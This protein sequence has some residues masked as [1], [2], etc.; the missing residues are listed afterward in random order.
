M[1]FTVHSSSLN[2][3]TN[4]SQLGQKVWNYWEFKN[5]LSAAVLFKISSWWTYHVAVWISVSYCLDSF[6][7]NFPERLAEEVSY[8]TV[9]YPYYSL[10]SYLRLYPLLRLSIWTK[11]NSSSISS[12]IFSLHCGAALGI[13]IH[14][15]GEWA[16]NFCQQHY[17][18]YATSWLKNT[19]V[20]VCVFLDWFMLWSKT[21]KHEEEKKTLAPLKESNLFSPHSY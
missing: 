20:C 4:R 16:S 6:V 2:T 11:R 10:C 18:Y 19:G 14:R 3:W 21:F 9:Q 13:S 7:P 1:Y 15:A 12:Q 8:C 5:K 17:S